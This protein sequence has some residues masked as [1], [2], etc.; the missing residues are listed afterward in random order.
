MTSVQ[1]IIWTACPNGITEAGRLRISVAIGPQLRAGIPAGGTATLGLFPDWLDWPATPITW[2]AVIDGAAVDATV[3]SAAPSTPL[4][5]ALF[6]AAIPVDPFEYQSPSERPLY[7]YPASY[8]HG[9]FNA[10]YT[11]LAAT[12]PKDGGWHSYHELVGPAAF[13]QFPVGQREFDDLLDE[14]RDSFPEGGGPIDPKLAQTPGFAAAM[15]YLFTQ[16][17]GPAS[18]APPPVPTFDFHQAYSL[19]QRHP[20]LLRLFGFV[21]DLEIARPVRAAN[22]R[23]PV[24]GAALDAE[25]RRDRDHERH[26]GHHDDRG[27]LA[28]GAAAEQ[29]GDRRRVAATIRSR[30]LPGPRA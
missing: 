24:G 20:G 7:S 6:S 5:R 10:L 19:L 12:V 21:V 3:V 14:V 25:A 30:R 15:A 8:L 17:L 1:R 9:L 11:H 23:E 18:T 27:H 16:P 28:G 13:G 2:Q 22:H 4:Y 29:P 26:A